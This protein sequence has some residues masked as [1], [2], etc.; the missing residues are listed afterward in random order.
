[1]PDVMRDG[2]AT[3]LQRTGVAVLMALPTTALA[4]G[5]DAKSGGYDSH[6][7]DYEAEAGGLP[8]LDTSII[9]EQIV[10]LAIVFLGLLWV[11]RRHGLPQIVATLS[12]RRAKIEGDLAAADTARQAADT[13][14]AAYEAKLAEARQE[15]GRL[16]TQ[17]TDQIA[18][19]HDRRLQELSRSLDQKVAEAVARIERQKAEVAKD[20]QSVAAEI[21]ITA[22]GRV[23]PGVA[24]DEHITGVVR[25]QSEGR[26]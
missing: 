25:S 9:I 21:A 5:G 14:M 20:V 3:Y 2:V 17:T 7:G 4:A 1:M 23:A 22:I 26:G 11:L 6:G 18:A 13:A 19:A 12:A 10:W 8:Q 15:A 24:S 16:F